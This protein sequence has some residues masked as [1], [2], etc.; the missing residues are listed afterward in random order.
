MAEAQNSANQSS[1]GYKENV[2]NMMEIWHFC[3]LDLLMWRPFTLQA[4]VPEVGKHGMHLSFI[5]VKSFIS[6]KMYLLYRL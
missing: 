5:K 1:N 4:E 6:H 2:E 3:L